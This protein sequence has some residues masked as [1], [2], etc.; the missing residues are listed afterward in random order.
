M[1][2]KKND[3]K[4]EFNDRFK[5]QIEVLSTDPDIFQKIL[6]KYEKEIKKKGK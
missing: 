3:I 5:Q 2:D 4:Q 1:T 6:K